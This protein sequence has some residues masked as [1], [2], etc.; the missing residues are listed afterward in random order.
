MDKR[1]MIAAVAMGATLTQVSAAELI[2][3]QALKRDWLDGRAVSTVG[4]RGGKSEFAFRPD[5]TLTR[6]GGRQGAADGGKWRLDEEGF[7]MT[8]GEAKQESCYVAI[9]S[10]G[11]A[12]RVMRRSGAFTWTR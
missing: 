6:T 2:G 10:E 3:P 5:G 1:W 8:L 4:P 9:R 11:G 12:I 7:C